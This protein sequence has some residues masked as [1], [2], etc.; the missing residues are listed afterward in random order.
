[1]VLGYKFTLLASVTSFTNAY[2]YFYMDAM[3]IDTIWD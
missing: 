2:E 1:M 3:R